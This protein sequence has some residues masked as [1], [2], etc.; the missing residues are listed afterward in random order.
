[1]NYIGLHKLSS[2]SLMMHMES[3]NEIYGIDDEN[4]ILFSL[5]LMI[6]VSTISLLIQPLPNHCRMEHRKS[7]NNHRDSGKMPAF[8]QSETDS[9]GRHFCLDRSNVC[10]E[11][12]LSFK[13]ALELS[14]QLSLATKNYLR[15]MEQLHAIDCDARKFQY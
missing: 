15:K 7:E 6:V 13:V 4:S 9:Y 8:L 1:M 12:E 11:N 10:I 5:A 2:R 14:K 3:S